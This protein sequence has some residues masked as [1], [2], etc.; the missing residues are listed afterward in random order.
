MLLQMRK[1][2][3]WFWVF[4]TLLGGGIFW[5][6]TAG[7][8]GRFS[9]R[10]E[11]E[12]LPAT[13]DRPGWMEPH[14]VLPQG[15]QAPRL[16]QL[17]AEAQAIGDSA[18]TRAVAF[19]SPDAPAVCSG[20]FWA[21]TR[22]HKCPSITGLSGL[23]AAWRHSPAVCTTQCNLVPLIPG[24]LTPLGQNFS[25]IITALRWPSGRSIA[26][27]AF[28]PGFLPVCVADRVS[29]SRPVPGGSVPAQFGSSVDTHRNPTSLRWS[30]ALK[31]SAELVHRHLG[32]RIP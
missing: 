17:A 13:Y 15:R 24:M 7:P 21:E 23:H 16:Q 25:W 1:S 10:G 11:A 26:G 9:G 30:S 28:L 18:L 6:F 27:V 12:A 14:G 4:L 29:T 20:I 32:N 3:L 5:L 31:G 8:G 2:R 22:G 19:L